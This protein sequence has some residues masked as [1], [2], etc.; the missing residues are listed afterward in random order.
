[1]LT[2]VAIL[3]YN[4][5]VNINDFLI[6]LNST[7]HITDEDYRKIHF[8]INMLEAISR[9]VY[10]SFYV[11]DYFKKNF[12]FVSANPLFLCG[13]TPDEIKQM[14]FRYYLEHVPENEQ[15]LLVEIK[16]AGLAFLDNIPVNERMKYM[17]SFD[18]HMLNGKRTKLVNQ[19]VTPV[20]LTAKGDIWLALC[21][22]SLSSQNKP[23]N[24]EIMHVGQSVFW[25]Y[26][27]KEHAWRENTDMI[28]TDREKEILLLS[29]Q[30]FTTKKWQKS[31][32]CLWIP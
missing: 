9:I 16:R 13:K 17:L 21:I 3:N 6:P 1:M 20:L 23:G 15:K 27:L 30:G 12:L 2:F 4:N 31:S 7:D 26:S 10:Q 32:V 8:S 11:I 19:R 22:I 25:K 14:G 18:F 5:M 24:I 29:A 28:L